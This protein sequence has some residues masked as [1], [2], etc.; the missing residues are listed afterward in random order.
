[1]QKPEII[2]DIAVQTYSF[3]TSRLF[4]RSAEGTMKPPDISGDARLI[5]IYYLFT[6]SGQSMMHT[7]SMSSIATPVRQRTSPISEPIKNN[8]I[9]KV[10]TAS[11]KKPTCICFI[12]FPLFDDQHYV[13]NIALTVIL[14]KGIAG[15]MAIVWK[16]IH[17]YHDRPD[18]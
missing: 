2:T 5:R 11:M 13:F 17:T 15:M 16:T 1:M 9:M 7:I 6:L 8:A 10:S 18:Q 14:S 4:R 12:V 3:S